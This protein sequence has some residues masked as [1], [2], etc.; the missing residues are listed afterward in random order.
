M[1]L[2]LPVVFKEAGHACMA[3][4][5]LLDAVFPDLLDGWFSHGLLGA[6]TKRREGL[7]KINPRSRFRSCTLDALIIR[8][9]RQVLSFSQAR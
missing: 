1:P 2:C 4:L 3:D 5:P 8:T 7:L 9:R 6:Y